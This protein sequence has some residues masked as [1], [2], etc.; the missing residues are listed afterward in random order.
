MRS[1]LVERLISF[2]PELTKGLQEYPELEMH[3]SYSTD[4]QHRAFVQSIYYDNYSY[5]NSHSD[6]INWGHEKAS[7][8]RGGHDGAAWLAHRR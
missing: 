7:R 3:A 1:F 5:H 4:A 8:R 6:W 2:K